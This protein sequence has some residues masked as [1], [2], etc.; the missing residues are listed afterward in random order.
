MP[1]PKTKRDIVLQSSFSATDVATLSL[2][3][4]AQFTTPR[5]TRTVNLFED[6]SVGNENEA[7]E[8]RMTFGPST[9]KIGI[10]TLSFTGQGVPAVK[11]LSVTKTRATSEI[12]PP[13]TTEAVTPIANPDASYTRSWQQAALDA[14]ANQMVNQV[15]GVDVRVKA[16][17]TYSVTQTVTSTATAALVLGYSWKNA[18]GVEI[19]SGTVTFTASSVAGAGY[20]LGTATVTD[21]S[22]SATRRR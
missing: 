1:T 4:D 16:G 12:D 2:G 17:D 18:S 22:P 10:I 15:G 11:E 21:T 13:P 3:V 20:S 8:Y 7:T 5:A 9:A 6:S 19:V 14:G